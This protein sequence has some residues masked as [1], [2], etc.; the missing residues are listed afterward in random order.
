MT[1][2]EASRADH[3]DAPAPPA[4]RTRALRVLTLGDGNFS[5]SLAFLRRLQQLQPSGA[6]DFVATSFDS[7]DELVAKYPE[8]V[9]IIEQLRELGATVLHRVDATNARVSLDAASDAGGTAP[10]DEIVFNHPHCGEENVQR[11]Q[12]LLSHFYVSA[13]ELLRESA[14]STQ[15]A[16]LVL[17]L[18]HGQPERWEARERARRAGLTLVEQHDD[19]DAHARYGVSYERK[20]HQNGKSFHRV[21]L[22]GERLQQQSTLFVF[23]P[24]TENEVTTTTT[25]TATEPA[26]TASISSSSSS[27]SRETE[28][29]T[30]MRAAKRKAE[31]EPPATEF[32]CAPCAKSF[33]T[34]QG[35][36]T[37]VR[38]VH[39]LGT[40]GAAA[41][42]AS[43]L[44]CDDCDRSFKQE[45]AL[46]QHRI[47]KHGRD[48]HIPPDWFSHQQQKE[49]AQGEEDRETLE[50]AIC[51][52]AFASRAAMDAHWT[53]LKPRSSERRRCSQCAR[54]FDEDRALRQHQNYC[55]LSAPRSSTT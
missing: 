3:G 18:A 13:K 54:E 7:H 22:H 37:H 48:R 6:I 34:A 41:T 55:L 43:L 26:P 14:T 27:L 38:M 19:A 36:R 42:S 31:S 52:L 12:S 24:A 2:L 28:T 53:Q 35:L 25:D 5:F 50:C 15:P 47:A 30:N 11:H 1:A 39:E 51:G 21:L 40:A 16:R 32:A 49:R 45:D 9:R 44:R 23:T 10:F 17:T 20:R 8:S 46:R 33:K 4:Q 29:E